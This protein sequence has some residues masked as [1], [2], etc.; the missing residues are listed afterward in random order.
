MAPNRLLILDD[1]P[2]IAALVATVATGL[3]FDVHPLSDYVA[4]ER[5]IDEWRPTHV[6][7][8]LQMPGRDGVETMRMLAERRCRARLVLISGVDPKVLE[9]AARLGRERGLDIVGAI[10][11]PWRLADLRTLL[12]RVRHEGDPIDAHA[13]GRA[14]SGGEL[15]LF[16]QPKV[17]MRTRA[18]IGYEALV[19]WQ[20]PQLGLVTP[21]RFIKAAEDS[22]HIDALTRWVLR[23]A[24]GALANRGAGRGPC[25]MAINISARSLGSLGLADELSGIVRERGLDCSDFTLE[26]TETVAMASPID[27]MDILTRLRL[28]GF[29]LAIDDFGTGYSSLVQL[30]RLPFSELKIDRS[31]VADCLQ[32]R[33]SFSIVK[34]IAALA[35]SLDLDAVAEGVESE[36]VAEALMG[37]GISFAQGYLYGRPAPAANVMAAA[38]EKARGG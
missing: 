17:D 28:K 22:G 13:I 24:A 8:D 26:V 37:L 35:Q 7:L 23:E 6:A 4:F 29:A 38:A 10:H 16:L 36:D 33:E 27:A 14:I 31:F 2:D 20:H 1:E 21:D 32:S 19:R 25:T 18:V 11:K 30:R 15:R 5:A 9:T 3:G 34:A 12:Q